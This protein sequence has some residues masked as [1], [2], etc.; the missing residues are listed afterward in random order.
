MRVIA[1]VF[2]GSA[3]TPVLS[4]MWPRNLSWRCLNTNFSG[5]SVAPADWILFSTAARVAWAIPLQLL[6]LLVDS[7][8]LANALFHN[9]QDEFRVYYKTF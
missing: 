3:E 8:C 9:L 2:S 1:L 6:I 7:F 4:M 5:L